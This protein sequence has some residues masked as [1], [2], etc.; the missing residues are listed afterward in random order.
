M[1]LA[2][3]T[4]TVFMIIIGAIFVI[5]FFAAWSQMERGRRP[6][7]RFLAPITKLRN[8]IEQSAETGSIVQYAPGNGG[9][10][11]QGGTP[12]TL[13]GLTT[14]VSLS[15]IAT[16]S[17]GQ[18]NI[19][20]DDTLTYVAAND[21][22]QL[23]YVQAGREEDYNRY[24]TRFVTQQDRVAF[25][26]ALTARSSETE[27]S[28]QILLG[29]FGDEI[30]LATERGVRRELPQ[31]A[32]STQVEALPLMLTTAGLKNT[33]IGEEIYATPAYMDKQPPHLASLQVQDWVRVAVIIAIIVGTIL[34]TIGYPIGNFLL[35]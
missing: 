14:Q 29:R 6:N 9:L 15:Q 12:E 11:G 24:D 21:I 19:Q 33:L 25:A 4:S 3:G 7:L 20:T 26:T 13:N 2:F 32:G 22:H 18:L 17:K 28:G 10:T 34:A 27:V 16:R 30:L 8:I 5:L 23:E 1:S 35:H 31:I